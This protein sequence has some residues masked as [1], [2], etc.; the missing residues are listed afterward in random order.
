ME[1]REAGV[2]CFVLFFLIGGGGGP[3]LGPEVEDSWTFKEDQCI[4]L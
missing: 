1:V 4:S 2:F 3:R